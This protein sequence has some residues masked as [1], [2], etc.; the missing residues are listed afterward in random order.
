[1]N[2]KA[3][4][5]EINSALEDI[6]RNLYA[7][8]LNYCASFKLVKCGGMTGRALQDTLASALEEGVIISEV[9]NAG[10]A[11]VLEALRDALAYQGV[12]GSHHPGYDYLMSEDFR[13]DASKVLAQVYT[14]LEGASLISSFQIEEGHPFYPVF[15]D[16]AFWIEK[17]TD[18]FILVG[19]SSD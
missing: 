17:G 13:Q 5:T 9:S 15:W 6:S 19:S 4:A 10:A 8:S 2:S 1:L 14:L 7:G 18:A 16:F 11:D 12:L 3:I